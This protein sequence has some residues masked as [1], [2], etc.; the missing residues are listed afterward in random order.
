MVEPGQELIGGNF[1]IQLIFRKKDQVGTI[2]K[3]LEVDFYVLASLALIYLKLE[4]I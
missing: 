4:K 2:E 1:N 3:D